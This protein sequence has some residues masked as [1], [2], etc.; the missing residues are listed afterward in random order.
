VQGQGAG[1]ARR[2]KPARVGRQWSSRGRSLHLNVG[3]AWVVRRGTV[4]DIINRMQLNEIELVP[5]IKDTILVKM[6]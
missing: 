3:D 2:R 4:P 1:E 5:V 6:W